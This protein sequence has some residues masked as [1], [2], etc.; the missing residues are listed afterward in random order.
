MSLDLSETCDNHLAVL[1][2]NKFR[3]IKIQ[4]N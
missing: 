1:K 4:Q 3:E 2:E